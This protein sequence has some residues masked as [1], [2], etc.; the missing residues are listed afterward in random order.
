MTNYLKKL[1]NSLYQTNNILAANKILNILKFAEDD[2]EK[3]FKEIHRIE[4]LEKI[5][6]I[7]ARKE[8]KKIFPIIRETISDFRAKSHAATNPYE[9]EVYREDIDRLNYFLMDFGGSEEESEEES[10]EEPEDKFYQGWIRL[11]EGFSPRRKKYYL[12]SPK[13][14]IDLKIDPDALTSLDK[15]IGKEVY[16]KGSMRANVLHVDS[17]SIREVKYAPDDPAH[18]EWVPF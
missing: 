7:K 12:D 16:L 17:E 3:L 2:Y 8:A 13:K 9:Q 18:P 5:D 11:R 15:F 4:D 14:E 10:K 1:A 6:P